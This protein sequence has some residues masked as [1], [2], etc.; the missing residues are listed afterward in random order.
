MRLAVSLIVASV[1]LAHAWGDEPR[2]APADFKVRIES[3]GPRKDPLRRA[4]LMARKGRAYWVM[5]DSNEVIV[6]DPSDASMELLDLERMERTDLSLQKLEDSLSRWRKVKLAATDKLQSA[7]GRANELAAGM[8]R[9]LVTPKF[10][11]SFDAGANRLKLSNASVD[12]DALGEPETDAVRRG[13]AA[14]ALAS[15]LKLETIRDPRSL[16]PFS[17]LEALRT[18]AGEHQSRPVEITFLYRLAGPPHKVRWTYKFELAL[19]EREAATIAKIDRAR[20]RAKSVRFD[21]YE[22]EDMKPAVKRLQG[23]P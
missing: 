6:Y 4:E 11:V 8:A 18:L 22:Q 1:L 14:E 19:S 23:G 21:R 12:V 9:D 15:F 2:P 10:Q 17:A 5:S 7:G 16:P 3:Y 13:F 20:E